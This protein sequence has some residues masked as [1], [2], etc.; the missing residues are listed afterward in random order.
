MAVGLAAAL[1]GIELVFCGGND[2]GDADFVSTHRQNIAAA[3]AAH[4]ADQPGAAQLAEKLL[5]IRERN[6]LPLADGAELY[7]AVLGVHGQI[8]HGGNGKAA[9]G[10]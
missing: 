1:S 7:R 9:F 4:A 3:G 5:Q 2:L 10:G 6:V 8:D